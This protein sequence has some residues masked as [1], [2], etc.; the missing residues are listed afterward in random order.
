M[1]RAITNA[2]GRL[3]EAAAPRWPPINRADGWPSNYSTMV[4]A[5]EGPAM[6]EGYMEGACRLLQGAGVGQSYWWVN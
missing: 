5:P 1:L 4:M 6:A 2:L 3:E